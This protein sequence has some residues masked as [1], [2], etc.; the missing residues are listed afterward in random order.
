MVAVAAVNMVVVVNMEGPSSSGCSGRG[1]GR[2]RAGPRGGAE[3]PRGRGN[4]SRGPW[5]R[6]SYRSQSCR[7]F[8]QLSKHREAGPASSTGNTGAPDG[9][10]SRIIKHRVAASGQIK[11]DHQHH[12]VL[13]VR[14]VYLIPSEYST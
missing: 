4:C 6:C 1:H 5:P 9:S 13:L 12:R 2:D 3:V 14:Q 11:L 8:S 7:Y 10:A